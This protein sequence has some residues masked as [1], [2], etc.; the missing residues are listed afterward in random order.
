MIFCDELLVQISSVLFGVPLLRN[1]YFFSNRNE[2]TLR[3]VLSLNYNNKQLTIY[4]ESYN[5]NPKRHH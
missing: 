2:E 3:E 1:P 4:D 5:A